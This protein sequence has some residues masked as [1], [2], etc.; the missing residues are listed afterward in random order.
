MQKVLDKKSFS[1]LDKNDLIAL[2]IQQNEILMVQCDRIVALEKEIGKLKGKLAK[3]S[4]DSGNPLFSYGYDKPKSQRLISRLSSGGQP[5]HKDSTLKQLESPNNIQNYD[6]LHCMHC[7]AGLS[8]TAMQTYRIKRRLTMMRGESLI[9]RKSKLPL[10]S[11]RRR[12]KFAFAAT[13]AFKPSF[14]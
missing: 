5:D 8:C 14:L 13:L 7:H 9:F 6:V 12:S 10:P 3:N 1:T 4:R 2:L 11:I